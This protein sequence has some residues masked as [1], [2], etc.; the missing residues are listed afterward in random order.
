MRKHILILSLILPLYVF[1]QEITQTIRG[2]VIDKITK[3]TLPGANIVLLNTDPVKG[4]TTDINGRFRLEKV[5]IGRVNLKISF[6]GYYDVVIS[7]LSLNSGKEMI[8]NIELDEKAIL[9]DEVEVVAFRSKSK[10]LNEMSSISSRG[11]TVEETQKYAGSRN[12]VARM[13]TN[14]AGV[15]GANDS[16]NDIVI[17]GNSPSGLLWRLEGVDIPSPN[18]YAAFGTTGG[19]VCIL[20]N[21]LLSNS[22]FMTGAFPAEYGNAVA[23]VFDLKMRNG[24]DEKYEFLGQIG[25]NGFE[26]GGEGPISKTKGST[27]LLNYRYSTLEV[28]E[29]LGVD[30]GTGTAIP[31][32]QDLSFKVNFPNT[33]LGSFSIF[34]IGGIS[35]ISF[36]DSKKDTTEKKLNFYSDEGTDLINGSDMAVIGL[37]NTYLMNK[38]TFTKIILSASYHNFKTSIDSISPETLE[39]LPFYRNNFTENKLFAS[40]FINK[41]LN[42]QHYFKTGIHLSN[43]GF[44]LVD[45]VYASDN[46]DFDVITNYTGST[47]LFQPYFQWQYK[48][49]N[50]L[51]L[52]AGLHYQ[53][54]TFNSTNSFEPRIGLKWNFRPNQILSLG[55]GS[56]SQLLPIT[57]YF[58]QSRLPDGSYQ[59]LNENLNMIQS[60]HLILGYDWNI[61]DHLR[62]KTEIYYQNITKAAVNGHK[63]DSYSILNQGADFWIPV[64]D[65]LINEGS[66]RNFGLE[67]TFEQF[68]NNGLY[69]LFTTSLYES[70]Y[71]G[72]DDVLRNTAFNGNYTVNMLAGKEFQIGTK[73]KNRKKQHTLSIDIKTTFAGGRRYTPLDIIRSIG[74][75]KRI[76]FLN[77]AYS[78][79]FKD[80]FRTDF[81]IAFKQNSKKI[82][83]EW[84]IDIQNI[85]NTQNIFDQNFNTQ[86]GEITYTHQLGMLII[87]QFRIV[88]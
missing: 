75:Q 37:T 55:Y 11:F 78:Q 17:R 74:E 62:L 20:N 73:N 5:S 42:S 2:K 63:K 71:K 84:A 3:E 77:K 40:F 22:D 32:Y 65:T 67:L 45:S 1:S 59:K 61:N 12:D 76:Y 35:D 56:H 34:G 69:Y 58:N 30:F 8:L 33:K 10:P 41:K 16:R 47:C 57:V 6:I 51:T 68:L 64:P 14:Y 43:M 29:K 80:Y 50:D 13:A 27:F 31:K 85:F 4:T 87:P 25:F 88:F 36:L 39:I 15:R 38:T 66:G 49:N 44:D 54:F 46:D 70:K 86:T 81:K 21:N 53:Y 9:Q 18:H 24:N 79:Q 52:N 19:P 60:Q 23:G 7:N 28:F 83:M 72:S 26:L 48:I 82:T